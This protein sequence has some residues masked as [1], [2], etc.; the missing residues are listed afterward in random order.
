M[1]RAQDC[2]ALRLSSWY[3]LLGCLLQEGFDGAEADVD[4]AGG[5]ILAHHMGLGK[6][7]GRKW[8]HVVILRF[9]LL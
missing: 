4:V 7:G 1:L 9:D 5:C 2:P 8:S 6:V 3:A